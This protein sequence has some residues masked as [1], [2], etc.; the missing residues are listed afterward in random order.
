[1]IPISLTWVVDLPAHSTVGLTD[2][3]KNVYGL[4][5]K[6]TRMGVH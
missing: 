4:K 1:M 6:L 2:L 3:S 5:Q